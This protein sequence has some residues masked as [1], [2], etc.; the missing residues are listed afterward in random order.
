MSQNARQIK[1]AA[2]SKC[3]W[4][5]LTIAS[6]TVSPRPLDATD[7]PLGPPSSGKC[8]HSQEPPPSGTIATVRRV[9]LTCLLIGTVA[10]FTGCSRTTTGFRWQLDRI[11]VDGKLLSITTL[12]GPCESHVHARARE[13]AQSVRLVVSARS[14]SG[15]CSKVGVSK[16]LAVKLARPLGSRKLLGCNPLDAAVDCS[17]TA[18]A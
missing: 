5:A 10:P 11:S 18:P 13:V 17:S 15:A 8:A 9:I 4:R 1:V 7:L 2:P 12:V 3:R 16:R 6:K 14:R